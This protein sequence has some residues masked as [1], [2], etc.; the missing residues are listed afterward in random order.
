MS[1]MGKPVAYVRRSTADAG[2]PGDVSREVQEGAIRA[3]AHRDGHNGDVVWF[4]DWARSADEEKE[5]RRTEFRAMLAAV[6]RGEVTVIY[7]FS[8][9]R[10]ARSTVTFGKLLKAAKDQD[11]R[12]VTDREG[13]LSDDGNPMRWAY[14]FLA[15]F[16]AEFEL[17]IAKA[18]AASVIARRRERGDKLGPTF[19]GDLPGEDRAA[20]V[21][22]FDA[23]GSANG[24]ARRLNQMLVD[25]PKH[26]ARPRR[27]DRWT[28]ATVRQVLVREGR[29]YRLGQRGVKPR[30]AFALSQLLRC[31]C[32]RML[33]GTL[34]GRGG[35][36]LYRCIMSQADPHHVPKSIAESRIL[37]W[38]KAE[39]ARLHVPHGALEPDADPGRRPALEE[40]RGRVLDNYEDGLIDK[41][42][43]DAKLTVIVD[44]IKA[45]DAAARL[46]IIPPTI[47]WTWSP[48]ALNDV[49]RAVFREV[50]LGPDLRPVRAEWLVPEWRS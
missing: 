27:S 6:E 48:T 33:T 50:Q 5:A 36:A 26:A 1:K 9:D 19:Y 37:P 10:L 38:V 12:I 41:A 32:G 45:I 7:A 42:A 24:A 3:M 28:H 21:A 40:R 44:E 13:D 31:H 25:D 8:L 35:H 46:D 17:R 11:V 22:A 49:L 14:G 30:G 20:I 43:R 47:D 2:N 16:F 29:I 4:V 39:A 18:R 34:A 15:S 23:V